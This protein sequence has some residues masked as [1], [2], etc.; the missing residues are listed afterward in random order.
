MTDQSTLKDAPEF[1]GSISAFGANEPDIAPETDEPEPEP[2]RTVHIHDF[3]GRLEV[4]AE[5]GMVE[6]HRYWLCRCSCGAFKKIKNSK[7]ITGHDSSCGNCDGL[8]KV[9]APPK[10]ILIAHGIAYVNGRKI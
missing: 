5:A 3:F 9:T 2:I 8:R 1:Y 7:L 10:S 4:L 6:S